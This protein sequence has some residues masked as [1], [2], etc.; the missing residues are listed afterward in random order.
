MSFQKSLTAAWLPWVPETNARLYKGNAC[1]PNIRSGKML[2][3]F[4]LSLSVSSISELRGDVRFVKDYASNSGLN[5]N[6]Y[7][8]LTLHSYIIHNVYN[9]GHEDGRECQKQANCCNDPS[10]HKD[11]WTENKPELFPPEGY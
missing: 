11:G 9:N 7:I 5:R 6:K 8:Q 4:I 2:Y 1:A 3:I 10:I